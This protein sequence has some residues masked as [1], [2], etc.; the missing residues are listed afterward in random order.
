[1]GGNGKL[2]HTDVKGDLLFPLWIHI[3]VNMFCGCHPGMAEVDVDIGI[4]GIFF[5]NVEK[6]SV[7]IRQIFSFYHVDLKS[8][9]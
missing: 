9:M 2:L 8:A 5:V 1:M 3:V 7:R 4:T 6:G